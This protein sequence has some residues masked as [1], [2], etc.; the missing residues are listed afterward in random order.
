MSPANLNNSRASLY[1][2]VN[3][4]AIKHCY[5]ALLKQKKIKD[6]FDTK[7]VVSYRITGSD[8]KGRNVSVNGDYSKHML[9]SDTTYIVNELPAKSNK[10]KDHGKFLA[11][12]QDAVNME[13]T[14]AIETITL[15]N[16]GKR[17]V[18]FDYIGTIKIGKDL[19]K[20]LR[21][22]IRYKNNKSILYDSNN[23]RKKYGKKH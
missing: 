6:E 11:C 16:D 14:F 10:S 3:Y 17:Y 5:D 2:H 9:N 23:T 13:L 4:T 1:G 19:C 22:N 12:Y 7:N 18:K 20:D 15:T 21:T 8:H